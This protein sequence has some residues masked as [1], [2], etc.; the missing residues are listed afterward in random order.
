M[1][2][3]I[4]YHPSSNMSGP[5]ES[6]DI[7]KYPRR[8]NKMLT[9]REDHLKKMHKKELIKLVKAEPALYDRKHVNYKNR[10]LLPKLWNEIGKKSGF[11]SEFFLFNPY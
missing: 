7:A 2:F 10:A 1:S 9:P 11:P 3:L 8:K 4:P 6:H 5:S